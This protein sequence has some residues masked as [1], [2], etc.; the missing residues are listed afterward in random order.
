MNVCTTNYL[1]AKYHLFIVMPKFCNI[2]KIW[3][4]CQCLNKIRAAF[5]TNCATNYITCISAWE[6]MLKFRMFKLTEKEG[7]SWGTSASRNLIAQLKNNWSV[8]RCS[9]KSALINLVKTLQGSN[10]NNKNKILKRKLTLKTQFVCFEH[11]KQQNL[12]YS[13]MIAMLLLFP[14]E[15]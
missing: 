7:I 11:V 13:N 5:G 14:P 1:S 9:M 2:T 12:W 3:Y 10:V 15:Y 4:I 8:S 6:K